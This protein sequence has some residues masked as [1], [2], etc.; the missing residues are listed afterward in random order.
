M[1][2][3]MD[4]YTSKTKIWLDKRF[5]SCDEQ[6]IYFAHQPI[7]GFRNGHSEPGLIDKYIRTC[8]IMKTLSHVKFDSLLDVGAAE[9]YKAYITNKLF[10]AKVHCC[11][12]SE[13]ACKRAAEIF[14]LNSTPA[15]S[16]DL[17]F[18]NNEFDV[19]LCSETLEHV[20]NLN[21]SIDELLRVAGK[22][23]II[24]VPHEPGEIIEKNI[25]EEIPH[26]HIHRFDLES[27]NFLESDGYRVISKKIV[28]PFL[29]KP[30]DLVEATP[31]KNF[32]K[33]KYPKLIDFYN[34]C[35]PLSR[36]LF[37]KRSVAFLNWLDDIYCKYKS[38]Y[39]AILFIILKDDKCYSKG[40]NSHIS[41]YQVINIKVPYHYLNKQS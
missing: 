4:Q 6:G 2:V 33:R 26:A 5:K 1:E 31:I 23:V 24:T 17:P 15:D 34:K 29:R 7:Y 22:A 18:K 12:L 39:T 41:S 37:G 13:E 28:S 20:V 27:F 32:K 35:L 3:I 9:G 19:V 11:D 30:G 14:K 10:G 40:K 25:A 8:Q 36:K 21:Q 38:S 16:C